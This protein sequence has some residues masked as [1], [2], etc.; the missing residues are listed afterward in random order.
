ME[1]MFSDGIT[2]ETAG[3]LRKL[4]LEDGWYVVG[5]GFCLPVDSEREADETIVKNSEP[6]QVRDHEEN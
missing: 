2:I 5:N 6:K 1:L 4:Q 3:P